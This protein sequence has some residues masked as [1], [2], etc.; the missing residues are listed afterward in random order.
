[1]ELHANLPE[2]DPLLDTVFQHS[3]F[4]T[5]DVEFEQVD[6]A[7]AVRKH[8]AFDGVAGHNLTVARPEPCQAIV[9][10]AFSIR[11]FP[12]ACSQSDRSKVDI[13]HTRF[14]A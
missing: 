7:M 2:V 5:F 13:F 3:V 8:D 12:S 6:S 14:S 11:N 1:M 4:E 9:I 10:S